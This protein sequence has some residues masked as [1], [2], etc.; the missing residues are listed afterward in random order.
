MPFLQAMATPSWEVQHG[1]MLF[2]KKLKLLGRRH[3]MGLTVFNH[4]YLLPAVEPF[5]E[6][7][8]TLSVEAVDEIMDLFLTDVATTVKMVIVLDFISGLKHLKI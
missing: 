1:V 3:V 5:L 8:L 4:L 6:L 2:L 7:S